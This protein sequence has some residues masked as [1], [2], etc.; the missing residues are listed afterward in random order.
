MAVA[1]YRAA[2]KASGTST[3]MEDEPMTQLTAT[4]AI[5]TNTAKRVLDPGDGVTVMEDGVPVACSVNYLSGV[6]TR[7]SGT[8][9]GTI[10]IFARYLPMWTLAECFGVKIN[11]SRTELEASIFGPEDRR[12]VLGEKFASGEISFLVLPDTVFDPDAPTIGIVLPGGDPVPPDDSLQ[13]VFKNGHPKLLEVTLD[14]D[15]PIGRAYWRGW[16]LFPGL[17]LS[18]APSEL[19]KLGVKWVASKQDDLAGFGFA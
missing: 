5:V 8:W 11:M 3:A 2:V 9:T 6:V 12:I 1:G 7:A 15:G 18:S 14:P 10:T 19:V 16:V 4:T 17:D 13:N